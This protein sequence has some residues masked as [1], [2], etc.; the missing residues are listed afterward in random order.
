MEAGEGLTGS[1][2]A[3]EAVENLNGKSSI[4]A[5]PV[6]QLSDINVI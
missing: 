3:G 2:Q 1:G 4:V 6:C 5:A